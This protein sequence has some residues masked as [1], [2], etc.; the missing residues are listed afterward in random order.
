[1]TVILPI[2]DAP[3]FYVDLF[4]LIGKYL[5]TKGYSIVFLVTSPYYPEARKAD[6]RSVGDVFFFSEYKPD[7]DLAAAAVKVN[8]KRTYWRSY[9]TYIRQLYFWKKHKNSFS[10]YERLD[11]FVGEVFD[12]YDDISFV[13]SE[14]ISNSFFYS[15]Y[16]ESTERGIAHYCYGEGRIPGFF[17]IFLDDVAT[18]S[19]VNPDAKPLNADST[20]LVPAY[21]NNSRFGGVFDKTNKLSSLFIELA[22]F[23][24]GKTY[25]SIEIGDSRRYIIR[26]YRKFFK[27]RIVDLYLTYIHSV[28][29]KKLEINPGKQYLLFPLHYRPEASTS[30]QAKYY[31]S[32]YEIIRNIAFSMNKDQILVV[33]EH[34]ANVGNN[35]LELYHKIKRLPNTILLD[36]YFSLKPN[37]TLFDAV[38]CITSTVG[39]EALE[40]GIPVYVLGRVF[41]ESYP[42]CTIV[43]SYLELEDAVKKIRKNQSIRVPETTER[44]HKTNFP[45]TFNYM[46]QVCLEPENIT[47]LLSPVL[48]LHENERN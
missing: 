29:D 20:K 40:L 42:G 32:D 5:K 21:M 43:N 35:S 4:F 22:R 33:K 41:Y 36:P 26:A 8:G 31:E 24:A 16:N 19:L 38:F 18:E 48:S 27:R 44:Y 10:D 2:A 15:V 14:L 1:M 45:G 37:L 30:V 11:R 28:F 13:I 7:S 12:R 25:K 34:K 6:L 9:S 46:L 39:F 47:N 23:S 3:G 17:N